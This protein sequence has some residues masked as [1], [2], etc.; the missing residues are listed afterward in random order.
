M[1]LSWVRA[2][3][4]AQ[5]KHPWLRQAFQ[6]CA[7][8][9]R[10][11]DG[12]IQRGA[13]KGL[14]FNPGQANAGYLLGTS[15]PEVQSALAALLRPGMTVYDVGANVGFLSVIAARLVGPA[16]RVVCFEPLPDNAR[17]IEYNA[18]LNGF[19]HVAVRAEALGAADGT[20]RFLLSAEPT[21][22]ALASASPKVNG[23][24]NEA[25]VPVRRLDGAVADAGLPLPE[26]IKIDVEGAEADVLAGA[27][28]TLG[29]ARPILMIELHGTNAAVADALHRLRYRARVLGR[30]TAVVD[31]PWN[32]YVIAAPEERAEWVGALD[33]VCPP[34]G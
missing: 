34:R 4:A 31:S 23:Q 6:W 7:R 20:A 12:Q 26:V 1:P 25:A 17:Q 3:S 8:R 11:Q 14:W 33:R 24:V 29:E 21:W 10:N 28:A 13:G 2:V 15:E 9:L 32:A 22:G 16:G 18:R 19:A 5:W 27:A 30:A